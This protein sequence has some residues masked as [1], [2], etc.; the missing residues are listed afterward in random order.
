MGLTATH[1]DASELELDRLLHRLPGIEVA[2]LALRDGQ[3]FVHRHRGHIDAAKLA[4]MSSSLVA[5]G[6]TVLKELSAGNLDHVLI[7][8]SIGKLVL[9]RLPEMSGMLILA[10]LASADTRLGMVLGLARTCAAAVG[11]VLLRAP[12]ELPKSIGA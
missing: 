10:V 6:G 12:V 7:V 3:P 9:V 8:G 1:R 4:A 5:L 2:S 11:E